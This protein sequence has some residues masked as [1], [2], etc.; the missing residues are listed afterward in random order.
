MS[1]AKKENDEYEDYDLGG[2]SQVGVGLLEQM[3]IPGPMETIYE[4]KSPPQQ[5]MPSVALV[6]SPG[7]AGRPTMNALHDMDLDDET[8][9]ILAYHKATDPFGSFHSA[10]SP[11]VTSPA[12]S[13]VGTA[14]GPA[15]S[16][17][18]QPPRLPSPTKSAKIN[19]KVKAV[20]TRRQTTFT[21]HDLPLPSNKKPKHC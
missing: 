3:N 20:K 5:H 9:C 14:R 19:K 8:Q 6:S 2:E 13:D 12:R 17:I 1:G 21:I 7:N 16:L 11:A 10:A 18:E 4:E 15:P